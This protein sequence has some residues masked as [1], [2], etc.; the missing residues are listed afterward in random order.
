MLS[1]FASVLFESINAWP[2]S[3]ILLTS[4]RQGINVEQ[5]ILQIGAWVEPQIRIFVAHTTEEVMSFQTMSNDLDNA[6]CG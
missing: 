1:D 2:L 3:L 4:N 5:D 6:I